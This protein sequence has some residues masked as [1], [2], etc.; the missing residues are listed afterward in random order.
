[1]TAVFAP[2]SPWLSLSSG[3]PW[4]AGL[5]GV[6]CS[7]PTSCPRTHVHLNRICDRLGHALRMKASHYGILS[8]HMHCYVRQQ[9]MVTESFEQEVLGNQNVQTLKPFS[10]VLK[11]LT[12]PWAPSQPRVKKLGFVL[13][14]HLALAVCAEMLSARLGC[15]LIYHCVRPWCW[16]WKMLS[17]SCTVTVTNMP[18]LLCWPFQMELFHQAEIRV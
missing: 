14:E 2:A 10:R 16:H 11:N 7:V 5:S 1:M 9:W 4:A 8:G 12:R 18:R 13:L 15:C 3:A 17:S 6:W